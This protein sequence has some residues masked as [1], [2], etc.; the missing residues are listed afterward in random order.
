MCVGIDTEHA[1][2]F[3]AALIPA[4]VEIKPPRV[5]I[6]F[7]GDAVLRAC[8]ENFFD[9]DLIAWRPQQLASGHVAE[10]GDKRVPHRAQDALCLRRALQAELSVDTCDEE[11]EAAQDVIGAIERAIRQNV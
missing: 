1:A 4:P 9:I 2:K 5:R 3:Q 11:I 6:D 7:N 8:L 10:H